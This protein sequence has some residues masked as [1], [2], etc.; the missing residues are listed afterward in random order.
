MMKHA[1]PVF[2]DEN[3][4]VFDRFHYSPAVKVGPHIYISGVIGADERGR[5]LAEPA[6]SRPQ[7]QRSDTMP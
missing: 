1:Q 2:A 4:A 5:A 6:T 7:K 3:H